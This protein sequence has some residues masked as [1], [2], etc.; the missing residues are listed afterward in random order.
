M[1]PTLLIMAAGLS[2]RYKLGLKQMDTFGPSGETLL[3]Y[4][5]Y[6]AIQAGFGKVVFVIRKKI[7]DD[8]ERLVTSKYNDKIDYEFVFQEMDDLPAGFLPP[9][10]REK[11]WGTGH[12]VW[13]TRNH[14]KGPFAVINA[15]DFY[16]CASYTTMVAF[17]NKQSSGIGGNYSMVGF[18]LGNT[19]SEYGSVSRGVC[20]VQNSQLQDI[21]ERTDIRE[22]DGLPV[23]TDENG[24]TKKLNSDTLVSM[25]FW[26]FTPDLFSRFEDSFKVFLSENLHD[27][28]S[29]FHLPTWIKN[30][31]T[32]GSA[33]V[34]VLPT[35]S[36]WIGVTNP[37][38]KPVV[39][40]KLNTFVKN[41][42][43][44][45]PLF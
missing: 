31:V 38:D 39:K 15:D 28:K 34:E 44:P 35:S 19:L 17:L 12:A 4:A 10:A 2:S 33:T 6:D 23:Y 1:K 37:D 43:Y 16:G 40:K 8:F 42:I 26:G 18:K 9:A 5:I 13:V 22:E 3:D 21:D 7:K 20:N 45:T 24:S 32:D 25:N 11:P 14:I 41:A 36:Q 30:Q 29:E 27:I